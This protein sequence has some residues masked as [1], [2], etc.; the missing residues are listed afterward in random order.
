MLALELTSQPPRPNPRA[1]ALAVCALPQYAESLLLHSFIGLDAE[2]LMG[3]DLPHSAQEISHHVGPVAP[4]LVEDEH[5]GHRSGTRLGAGSRHGGAPPASAMMMLAQAT[6]LER[7]KGTGLFEAIMAAFLKLRATQE[8]QHGGHARGPKPKGHHG[9]GH[10]LGEGSSSGDHH[11]HPG[12]MAAALGCIGDEELRTFK[13][14]S[15]WWKMTM[16]RR[17]IQQLGSVHDAKPKVLFRFL[18]AGQVGFLELRAGQT[19]FREGDLADGI[20]ILGAGRL[21]ISRTLDLDGDGAINNDADDVQCEIYKSKAIST[22]VFVGEEGIF[23]SAYETTAVA[24][25]PCVVLHFSSA[26]I[27]HMSHEAVDNGEATLTLHKLVLAE[28]GVRRT[29]LALRTRCPRAHPCVARR[30]HAASLAAL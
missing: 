5:V 19:L 1:L 12:M 22:G 26:A 6:T 15:R 17:I 30:A 29:S 9:P 16:M 20:Y 7:T 10:G 14:S 11:S 28:V 2:E 25:S 13:A 4:S 24:A 21:S 3:P 23:G 8:V 27:T 18:A